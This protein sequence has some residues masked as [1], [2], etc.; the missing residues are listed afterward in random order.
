MNELILTK[1][2]HLI[3]PLSINDYINMDGYKAI[4]K[5]LNNNANFLIE[6]IKTSGLIGKGGANFPTGIKVETVAKQEG[7]KY[8][9][10]N[11]DEGEPGNFKD[12]Y[13]IE[14]DPHSLIEGM[15][16][17][18]YII[19]CDKAYIYV[20]EEYDKSRNTLIEAIKQAK[21]NGFLGNNILN[22]GFSLEI[23]IHSGAGSYLCG[24]ECALIS[25]IEGNKG[26]TR[27]KP[28]FPAT[29]GL[30]GKPTLLLNVETI[31]NIPYIIE[32]G[33][34]EYKIKPTK[35]VSLSGNVNV[36]GVFE[37]PFGTSL[38]TVIED[39]GKTKENIK[40]ILLGGLSAPI[41]PY[42]M[43]DIKLDYEELKKENIN[44]GSGGIIVIN[45]D[46][47]LFEILKENMKFFRYESCGKCT[48]CR[49]GIR[50]VINILDK[51]INKTATE[52]DLDKLK[53]LVNLIRNTSFCGL[54]MYSV[55]SIISALKYFKEEF[56][57]RI[58][59]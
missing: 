57:N 48:P 8:L 36:K 21:E 14:H 23:E 38:R 16:I 32:H 4:N 30:F 34:N 12:K 41:I 59:K 1:R 50:E 44:L 7:I 18:S 35:L 6:E 45:N 39:Y 56:N 10:C 17:L 20:R 3:D 33:G 31:A 9:I 11:A 13:L 53:S 27:I 28:P 19:G 54:G 58:I 43:I 15:I 52:E 49:E 2:V 55:T 42:K 5:A 37:I 22:T 29:S 25:S 47:D 40:M 51:F 26:K 24:E 46:Y